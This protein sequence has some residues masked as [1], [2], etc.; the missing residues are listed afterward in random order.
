M[1]ECILELQLNQ[2]PFHAWFLLVPKIHQHP[3]WQQQIYHNSKLCKVILPQINQLIH[4]MMKGIN[5]QSVS[6]THL[7]AH[8][9]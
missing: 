2:Q 1:H 7:R 5:I 9:T 4:G 6:Y 3:F 8:E